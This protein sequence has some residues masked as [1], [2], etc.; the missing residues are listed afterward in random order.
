[1]IPVTVS[2]KVVQ[3]VC[4]T[5]V[6]PEVTS[7]VSDSNLCKVATSV[8]IASLNEYLQLSNSSTPEKGCVKLCAD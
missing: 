6:V 5:T 3:F 4:E 1:M 7:A 8:D 2:T